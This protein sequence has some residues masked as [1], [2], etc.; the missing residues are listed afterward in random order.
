MRKGINGG[1]GIDGDVGLLKRTALGKIAIGNG[2]FA[3]KTILFAIDGD[4]AEHRLQHTR[5][6]A[7][8]VI[9]E[10]IGKAPNTKIRVI[11]HKRY[12]R[13]AELCILIHNLSPLLFSKVE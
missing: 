2:S 12:C 6:M 13:R 5:P 1:C 3:H 11:R 7:R 4:K 10:A 8:M 9:G